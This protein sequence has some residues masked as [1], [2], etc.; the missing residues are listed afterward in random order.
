MVEGVTR[1]ASGLAARSQAFVS[2]RLTER[3]AA[4]G[5]M[6]SSLAG[7]FRRIAAELRSSET[8]RGSSRV[9]DRG[10]DILERAGNYLRSADGERLM[11]DAGNLTHQHKWVIA[12]AALAAGFATSRGLK[13]TTLGRDQALP[14]SESSSDAG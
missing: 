1:A 8:I 3:A 6:M 12:T 14:V 13:A 2:A 4:A 7:D 10:A 11:A 9:A 5:T